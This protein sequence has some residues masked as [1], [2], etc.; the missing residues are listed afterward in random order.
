MVTHTHTDSSSS[1]DGATGGRRHAHSQPALRL[2]VVS[3]ALEGEQQ[4]DSGVDV[5]ARDRAVTAALVADNGAGAARAL[6]VAASAETAAKAKKVLDRFHS[7]CFAHK[8]AHRL[9]CSPTVA[10]LLFFFGSLCLLFVVVICR[11]PLPWF[12]N[13][14]AQMVWSCSA[15]CY[16]AATWWPCAVRSDMQTALPALVPI[17]LGSP[18]PPVPGALRG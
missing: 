15:L 11:L 9:I 6:P 8:M 12:L 4:R 14:A 2:A 18:P 13:F 16:A 17:R 3:A 10:S 1:S 5:D 7:F